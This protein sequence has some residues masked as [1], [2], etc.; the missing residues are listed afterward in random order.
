MRQMGKI[1]LVAA[2]LALPLAAAHA[3]KRSNTLVVGF[4]NEVDTLDPATGFSGRRLRD[5]RTASTSG[6]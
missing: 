3:D 6:W 2:A 1:C 5:S 4:I